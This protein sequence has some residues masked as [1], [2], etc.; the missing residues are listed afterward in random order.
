M[1]SFFMLVKRSRLKGIM[2]SLLLIILFSISGTLIS[3]NAV[4]VLDRVYG[5]DQTLYNG[6]KYNYSVPSSTKGHQYLISPDY[7]AGSVTLR[8]KCYQDINLNYDIFNQ[9]L[10][11]QYE[12]EKGVLNI[13]EVSKAW[14]KSFRR[15]NL[16][17]EFLSLEKEPRFYQVL[18]EGQVRNSEGLILYCFFDSPS[19]SRPDHPSCIN[20]D[21]R[22]FSCPDFVH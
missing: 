5:L 20:S 16:N 3:Q 10:L 1:A 18:G 8:G 9:Q 22:H 17:F 19:V 15:G 14:L 11:L 21:F 4:K 13:I 2:C 12:D 6:K 7:I